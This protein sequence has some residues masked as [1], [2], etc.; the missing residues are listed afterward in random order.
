MLPSWQKNYLR[1]NPSI[2]HNISW[3]GA[4]PYFLKDR[5]EG[6]N[7]KGST[8]C[9]LWHLRVVG[10]S[11]S[12]SIYFGR[13]PEGD[14]FDHSGEMRENL[15]EGNMLSLAVAGGSTVSGKGCWD[16]VEANCAVIEVQNPKWNSVRAEP[17]DLRSEKEINWEESSLAKFSKFLGFPT[18]GLEKEILGFFIKIRKRRERINNKGMLE[19]SKFERELKRLE[20][21]INYKGNVKKNSHLK[22]R[23][24]QI[25]IV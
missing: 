11:L 22:G 14:F 16:L 13:S 25:T 21:S 7:K 12:S 6:L 1:R 5:I 20:C 19:K 23:G 8:L 4:Y 17:Q 9:N 10:S 3:E 2:P 18:E 15:Q 24:G